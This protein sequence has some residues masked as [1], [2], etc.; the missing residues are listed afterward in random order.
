MPRTARSLRPPGS[1]SIARHDD[2]RRRVLGRGQ[3][4]PSR[5]AA[6]SG[7]RGRGRRTGPPR[8]GQGHVPVV[9][10]G[11]ART[12]RDAGCPT[13]TRARRRRRRPPGWRAARWRGARHRSWTGSSGSGGPRD[14]AAIDTRTG[15]VV[16]QA[17]EGRRLAISLSGPLDLLRGPNR[18]P[19]HAAW[20]RGAM[21]LPVMPPV[22]PMLAKLARELPEADDL[23]YEPK[24]DGFRCIV[25]RD[26]DEVELGSR[27]ERPLTRYFPE[28]IEPLRGV[29]P[30][31]VRW[32]TARSSSPAPGAS[33]STPCSS[34]STRPPPG[35]RC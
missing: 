17:V 1:T 25:F 22:A 33:T 4:A 32:S 18:R 5:R 12:P 23:V 35:S 3:H 7:C 21:D 13:P 26:G 2:G 28:L 24:W 15:R 31:P 11:H 30:D 20:Q 6:A 19:G 27:N 10:L 16:R 8:A 9:R 34:A 29:A 14:V